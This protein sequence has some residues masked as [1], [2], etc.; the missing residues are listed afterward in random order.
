MKKVNIFIKKSFTIGFFNQSAKGLRFYFICILLTVLISQNSYSKN[1]FEKRNTVLKAKQLEYIKVNDS[2]KKINLNLNQ[3]QKVAE[4]PGGLEKFYAIIIADFDNSDIDFDGFSKINVSFSIEKD[5]SL[6]A[7]K[8][9][10]KIMSSKMKRSI[11][12]SL[13]SIK[14]KWSPAIINNQPV[15]SVYDLPIVFNEKD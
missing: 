4:F 7:V 15:R 14:T 6:S 8:I 1:Y 12:N 13:K 2:V 9:N 10:D 5:G 11:V 3:L